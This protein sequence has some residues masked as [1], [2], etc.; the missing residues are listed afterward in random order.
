MLAVATLA[1]GVLWLSGTAI[2]RVWFHPLTG[3]PGPILAKVSTLYTF[4]FNVVKGG[5][6]YREIERMHAEY[7]I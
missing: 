5:L 7:G 2:Y 4:Y 1:V 3:V 6:Y